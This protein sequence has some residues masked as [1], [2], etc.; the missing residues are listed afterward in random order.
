MFWS[1]QSVSTLTNPPFALSVLVIF[2]ACY[3]LVKGMNSN[4]KKSLSISSFLF[5]VLIIIK[6]Y[7][8]ILCLGAL[9]VSGII[10]AM[11][12]KGLALIKVFA[13][14]SVLSTMLFLPLFAEAGGAV[15]F[16]PFWFLETMMT[17]PDRLYYF[18]FAQAMAN[19]KEGGVWIKFAASY[20]IAFVIFIMGNFGTRI[21]CLAKVNIKKAK[22]INSLDA[23]FI[24]LISAGIILPTFFVQKNTAWNTIQFLYYSLFFS[25]VAAGMVFSDTLKLFKSKIFSTTIV[26]LLM[27]MTTPAT[28]GTLLRHYLPE[29]PPAKLSHEEIEALRFL[30]KQ[31]EGTVL[32]NLFDKDKADEAVQNPPRPLYLYEST[33]Y[34][35]AFSGKKVFLE[36]EV[37]LEIMEYNWRERKE[38]IVKAMQ[39]DDI[40]R[41][42]Y[43][44]KENDIKYI[45]G[46][47]SYPDLRHTDGLEKIF[48][49]G[50]IIIYKVYDGV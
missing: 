2:S 6:V 4:D 7:A 17:A 39:A 31:P 29:R 37:N 30:S 27:A 11:K 43:F 12:R 10:H 28:L 3:Y 50:E 34:V 22:N 42:R 32:T 23:F 40:K 47:K 26:F 20:F 41:F 1:Q 21:I 9:F 8:G 35:S 14:A 36:D 33:A 38:S 18:R 13:G 16:K 5:G 15:V 19:Y 48:E 45:Y 44:L 24:F 49:N 46:L 25:G